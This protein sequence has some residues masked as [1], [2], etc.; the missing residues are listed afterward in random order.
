[1][2]K[3]EERGK[4]EEKRELKEV[5][6]TT[7]VTTRGLGSIKGNGFIKLAELVLIRNGL[8]QVEGRRESRKLEGGER[9]E[10]VAVLVVVVCAL[11]LCPPLYPVL[12][13]TLHILPLQPQLR[14]LSIAMDLLPSVRPLPS[15]LIGSDEINEG[16]SACRR[17]HSM[18]HRSTGVSTSYRRGALLDKPLRPLLFSFP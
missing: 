2:R 4:E 14:A 6:G 7:A 11:L 5:E 10:S 8:E 17:M 13:T 9:D 1:M 18:E 12:R 3:W 15:V 16:V